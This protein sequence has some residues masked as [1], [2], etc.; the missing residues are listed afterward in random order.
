MLATV[1]NDDVKLSPLTDFNINFEDRQELKIVED[2]IL[3]LQVILPGMLSTISGVQETCKQHCKGLESM[4]NERYELDAII[5]EF[6]EYIKESRMQIDRAKAL[7][8]MAKSTARLV[9]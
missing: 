7:R 3:D 5:G 1:G 6:D 4:Y 8:D 2:K 9:S